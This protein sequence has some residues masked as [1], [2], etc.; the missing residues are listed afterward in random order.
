MTFDEAMR[1]IAHR[2][3]QASASVM[4]KLGT[5][6]VKHEDD[7]TGVLV[8]ALDEAIKG[9]RTGGVTWDTSILTHRIGGEEG[10]Y[11]ADLLIHV[12]LDTPQHKY[13]KGVLVQA[14]RIGPGKNMRA[15]D[16]ADLKNQCNKM[17]DWTPASFVFAYDSHGMR[18][19][20]A[21]KIA[22]S[23]GRTLYDQCS[24]TA[25][26][27]FLELFRCPIGDTEITSADVE[28][29]RMKRGLA[30]RGEGSLEADRF[31]ET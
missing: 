19:G 8:G 5:G 9:V 29:L 31:V 30:I 13:S 23:A 17:L 12:R 16:H 18:C 26:R 27:F 28:E 10:T 25:Y 20:A 3:E 11:G 24:W 6:R 7:L 21:T 22:G 1:K 15:K 14:K 4:G 2:A